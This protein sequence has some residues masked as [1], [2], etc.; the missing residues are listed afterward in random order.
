M[1]KFYPT[2]LVVIL[3]LAGSCG[4]AGVISCYNFNGRENQP[5]E[6]E[7]VP[8]L[9]IGERGIPIKVIIPKSGK[10]HDVVVCGNDHGRKVLSVR[11]SNWSGKEFAC[12]TGNRESVKTVDVF[13]LEM[14]FSLQQVRGVT[15]GGKKNF[16]R[17]IATKEVSVNIFNRDLKAGTF[18]LEI[19]AK[20]VSTTIKG[21]R[22]NEYIHFA[23]TADTDGTLL[24]YVNGKPLA[25]TMKKPGKLHT[26]LSLGSWFPEEKG[27]GGILRLNIDDL[28]FCDELLTPNRFSVLSKNK[29]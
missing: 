11:R 10:G 6:A 16:M 14:V 3:F 27:Y 15:T 18:S 9:K 19:A 2:I 13:T 1:N 4:F 29:K 23:L 21:L 12:V 22:M 5:F 25:E 20:D 8:D 7:Y 24:A 26:T 17:L 28:V